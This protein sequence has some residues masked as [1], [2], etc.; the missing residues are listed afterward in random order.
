MPNNISRI[1]ND[2]FGKASCNTKYHW[3]KTTD[4]SPEDRGE[5]KLLADDFMIAAEN[6]FVKKSFFDSHGQL[7]KIYFSLRILMMCFITVIIHLHKCLSFFRRHENLLHLVV[8]ANRT[9]WMMRN[10]L[11]EESSIMCEGEILYEKSF[12]S[13][14]SN[15]SLFARIPKYEGIN[16]SEWGKNSQWRRVKVNGWKEEKK[17]FLK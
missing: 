14:K 8:D 7:E 11:P 10:L 5:K 16:S 6:I 2:W 3:Q 12:S 17:I 4:K 1:G 13:A 9:L 15:W